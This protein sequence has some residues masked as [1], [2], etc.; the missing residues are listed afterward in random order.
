MN[1]D[2]KGRKLT[3]FGTPNE[4][5]EFV[6]LP[7]YEDKSDILSG[8]YTMA[9]DT[10]ATIITPIG[11]SHW[12]LQGSWQDFAEIIGYPE[13]STKEETVESILDIHSN[14]KVVQ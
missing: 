4:F 6:G 5:A 9:A 7:D 1:L 14:V 8:L 11:A 12:R 13:A 2:T 3:L 10:N